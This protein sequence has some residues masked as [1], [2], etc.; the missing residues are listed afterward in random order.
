MGRH[1]KVPQRV[2][3]ARDTDDTTVHL[4]GVGVYVGD[5]LL[6]GTPEEPDEKNRQQITEILKEGDDRGEPLG[7]ALYDRAVESGDLTKEEAE[8]RKADAW[9]G[10][11]TYKARPLEERVLELWRDL[12]EN[13]CIHLDSGDIVWGYQCW[14]GPEERLA[15]LGRTVEI[16]P[17]P[18]VNGRWRD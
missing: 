2:F 14:W 3:A 18:E 16:V 11:N 5:L 15:E 10:Y 4:F 1:D 6:P 8:Q 9:E 12:N 13:P 17:V 7:L